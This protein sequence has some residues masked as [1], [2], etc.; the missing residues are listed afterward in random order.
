M[1]KRWMFAMLVFVPSLAQARVPDWWRKAALGDH[2]Q[3]DSDDQQVARLQTRGPIKLRLHAIVGDVEVIAGGDKAITVK[4]YET[5]G[6]HIT[7]REEGGDR[8][9]LLFND[10]PKLR[11]GRLCVEVPAKS[12]IDISSDTGDLAVRGVSGEVRAR[13]IS[14]DVAVAD[15]GAVDARSISGDVA[16]KGAQGEVRVETVSGD[17]VVQTIGA[18]ARVQASTT[19]GD[20]A[21]TGSCG[22]GCRIEAR[23]LSGDIQLAMAEKS[24]FALHFMT[25]GGE[26]RDEFKLNMAENKSDSMNARYGSGDGLVEAQTFSG[27]LHLARA[28]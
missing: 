25:H 22:S 2:D 8:V 27:D 11:C 3:R 4:A 28:K 14:G 13:S 18:G 20:V 9:V 19:S 6:A 16:V 24:S 7:F 10:K 15:A 1:M 23:T 17:V 5:G 12:S 26:V 21:W